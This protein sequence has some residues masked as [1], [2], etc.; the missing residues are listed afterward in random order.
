MKG[1]ASS[2]VFQQ[3]TGQTLREVSTYEDAMHNRQLAPLLAAYHREGPSSCQLAALEGLSRSAVAALR[4]PTRHAEKFERIVKTPPLSRSVSQDGGSQ[5]LRHDALVLGLAYQ[6]KRE[7]LPHQ[8]RRTRRV[9]DV[10]QHVQRPT[11]DRRVA[12]LPGTQRNTA[13]QV[14]KTPSNARSLAE[15]KR[16][17]QR[18]TLAI[19]K[20]NLQTVE[21]RLFVLR[22]GLGVSRHQV[23]ERAK[24]NVAKVLIARRKKPTE[25]VRP[26]HAQP[27]EPKPREEQKVSRP[28]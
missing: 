6:Q 15:G 9:H 19:Q 12:S 5:L 10:N 16:P 28:R 18:A 14:Q 25:D 27:C 22:Y 24:R 7:K 1:D 21:N 26:Q 13:R 23:F 8:R 4:V 17:R 2:S 3:R 20:A 11:A